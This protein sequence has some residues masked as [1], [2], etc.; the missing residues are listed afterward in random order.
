MPLGFQRD[1][2]LSYSFGLNGVAFKIVRRDRN[3]LFDDPI[4]E[5]ILSLYLPKH[6][7]PKGVEVVEMS[8]GEIS[9]HRLNDAV[10]LA[11]NELNWELQ[12]WSRRRTNLL[13]NHTD[14]P[15]N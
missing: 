4:P 5:L 3:P 6:G 14:V 7:P 1:Q 10:I 8:L 11:L 12:G 9:Q 2:S 15:D 13:N